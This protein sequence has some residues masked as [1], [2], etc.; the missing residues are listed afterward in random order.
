MKLRTVTL[1]TRTQI[2][3]RNEGGEGFKEGWLGREKDRRPCSSQGKKSLSLSLPAPADFRPSAFRSAENPP[4]EQVSQNCR[5]NPEVCPSRSPNF[6]PVSPR[7]RNSRLTR[8]GPDCS[9]C[10]HLLQPS[11]RSLKF[12]VS[13]GTR[14]IVSWTS[15]CSTA[16]QRPTPIESPWRRLCLSGTCDQLPIIFNPTFQSWR[17]EE[18]KEKA[19]GFQVFSDGAKP[20]ISGSRIRRKFLNFF[21]NF[22][23][24][25]IDSQ[26]FRGSKS[27]IFLNSRNSKWRFTRS[28]MIQF[29]LYR[30]ELDWLNT[31]TSLLSI[32]Y[33]LLKKWVQAIRKSYAPRRCQVVRRLLENDSTVAISKAIQSIEGVAR[34]RIPCTGASFRQSALQ[35]TNH[36]LLSENNGLP[37]RQTSLDLLLL[38]TKPRLE[39]QQLRGQCP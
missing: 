11:K 26:I 13:S 12:P 10:P 20:W 21:Y 31:L 38:P 27:G 23:I 19:T 9:R 6:L 8:T 39:Q 29:L 14:C 22:S 28:I 32:D 30:F 36:P 3:Q 18:G 15:I 24:L 33:L 4:L 34:W 17:E 5:T 16:R 1:I 35:L 7:T 2:N 25:A 37:L